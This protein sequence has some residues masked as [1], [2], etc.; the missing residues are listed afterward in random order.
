MILARIEMSATKTTNQLFLD[1]KNWYMLVEA[2]PEVK[3]LVWSSDPA[4]FE[5]G[6][7]YAAREGYRPLLMD[8]TDDVLD[9]AKKQIMENFI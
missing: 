5:R 4:D 6:I 1:D 9:R 7:A 2:A 8:D 3:A